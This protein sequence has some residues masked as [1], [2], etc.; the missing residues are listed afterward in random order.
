MPKSVSAWS[1]AI[2]N[3][4]TAYTSTS[5][6]TKWTEDYIMKDHSGH[7]TNG[8]PIDHSFK[9]PPVPLTPAAVKA[10]SLLPAPV[11]AG[12][13]SPSIKRK[14]SA[15][16]ESGGLRVHWARIRRRLGTGTSPSTSSIIDDSAADGSIK[17]RQFS[18]YGDDDEVDEVVVDRNWSEEMKSSVSQSDM[19]DTPERPSSHAVG[20]AST[21][22]DSVAIHAEGFWG[23]W[24]PFIIIRW[25]IWPAVAQFFSLR[26]LDERAESYYVKESWFMRKSL[27]LW[28]TVFLIVNWLLGTI[29]IPTPRVL[30]DKV[31]YYGIAPAF[32]FPLLLM[33][34]YDWPRDRPNSYQVVLSIAI[35]MWGLYQVLFIFLCGRYNDKHSHFT[36][37]NKDFL[38]LFY[39]V[40]GLPTMAMFGL[41]MKRLPATLCAT[42]W[43][44]LALGLILPDRHT[45][46]RNILNFVLF[47]A[48]LIYVHYMLE[49]SERR[50]YILRDRLKIQFRATQ[51]AQVNE[52]KA[53]DSKRRLTSYVFHE[54]R[55][56]LNTALL[57]V[58]NMDAAGLVPRSQEVEFRA[59]EGSLSMMSK[60][61]NDVLDFNRMDSGRFESVS[62]PYSFH[63]VMRSLFVPL[64]L[65]ADARHLEF[66]TD[67]DR[68]IDDIARQALYLARGM[69]SKEIAQ[70]IADN[71][72]ED[73]IVVGD[74]TR[75][76]QIITNLASNACKFTPPG[77]VLRVTTKLLIPAADSPIL[78]HG[79]PPSSTVDRD[80]WAGGG[81]EKEYGADGTEEG[82]ER[83]KEGQWDGHGDEPAR[84][85]GGSP[86][87]ANTLSHH[88][89]LHSKPP[90]WIVVRIEVTD[91]GYGIPP[92]DMMQSKLFS[93][94]NQTEQ[95]KQQG[96]KGTGLG[97]ALVRQI[98]KRSGGRLGVR[99]KVGKG[100]TF[101]VEMPLGIGSK[102]N[103]APPGP[104]PY[105]PYPVEQSH[106]EG[107]GHHVSDSLAKGL[108]SNATGS[109]SPTAPP[110][111]SNASHR[112]SSAMQSLMEQGGLVELVTKPG[113]RT[114]VITR[115]LNDTIP[116]DPFPATPEEEIDP[117]SPIF[118]ASPT[119]SSEVPTPRARP[120]P[121][122][123]ISMPE[124][125]FDPLSTPLASTSTAST[126][127]NSDLHA[128]P[129]PSSNPNGA[130]NAHDP[131]P[132]VPPGLDVLVVDDDNLTRMLMTRMLTRL[133]CK[134]ATAEN[135][136]VAL[137]MI[138]GH[139][140]DPPRVRISSRHPSVS[141]EPPLV[142]SEFVEAG[143][144]EEVVNKYAVVFL[145]NQMPVM[146]GLK[147]VARLRELGRKDFV[148]GVTGNALLSDQEE[149]LEAGVD[150]VL[151][152]PVLERSLRGMLAK[153]GERR[154]T[155][156]ADMSAPA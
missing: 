109:F 87:S 90:E 21:D 155:R 146:S 134:V 114:Q 101:W 126:A 46:I 128:Q 144:S 16:V 121:D 145:D 79:H 51:K 38:A 142:S 72:H 97:L 94:F 33:I 45:W 64:R 156:G 35:W 107:D 84:E 92:K 86:L 113:S 77:G 89:W 60:V 104:S 117:P 44:G 7:E 36:C 119:P 98:V 47:Q 95:G 34:M 73:G 96:G 57:A 85:M 48:F 76:M 150:Y 24:T 112:S 55:V 39:Y 29:F 17:R 66:S 116:H 27:A 54:V 122:A 50:L 12:E 41:K 14:K 62:K 3:G 20:G 136:D 26:F 61:L 6:S 4:D 103:S 80:S 133:G 82:N 123:V 63:Q 37:G 140:R 2:S 74:E 91:S 88:N 110:W 105:L 131:P 108:M 127:V 106:P 100:S 124:P 152:K 42:S 59:L 5:T 138:M 52:R 9:G 93:A 18:T 31:F 40:C 22:H 32:T 153:A 25:R 132:V 102:A 58:Q 19:G 13:G 8:G 75:L 139:V 143:P 69:D 23:M 68:T 30:Y 67:L 99:S 78:M 65:A 10:N 137:Q 83:Q 130:S 56:P 43:A 111:T 125:A 129:G 15:R 149:Y 141:S 81:K 148:V 71:P 147:A 70:H 154:N 115:T 151:T 11:V 1:H 120:G 118:S 28:S 53:A 135:G 49:T